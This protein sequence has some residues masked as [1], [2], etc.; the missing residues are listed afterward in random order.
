MSSELLGNYQDSDDALHVFDNDKYFE[1]WYFDA[2]FDNGYS[3]VC[4]C[5]WMSPYTEPHRPVIHMNIYTPE[6]KM[7]LGFAALEPKDC[8][9][10]LK[11]C[12]FNMAGNSVYQE[13]DKYNM[14]MHVHKI[15]ADLCFKKRI[16]GWKQHGNGLLYDEDGKKQGWIIAAPRSDVEGT[17]MIKGEIVP[18]KGQG[19]HDK[20]FGNCE[21]QDC[22]RQ[23]YWGRLYDDRFTL[24]YYW[25]FPVDESKPVIARLM[26]ALDDKPILVSEK[27]ELSVEKQEKCSDTGRDVPRKIALQGKNDSGV[28]FRCDLDISIAELV[29]LPKLSEF[30][31]YYWRSLGQHT[32]EVDDNCKRIVSSGKAVSEYFIV[33]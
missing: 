26:L 24:I 28:S 11:R 4:V 6:D 27:Y 19:Y 12:N 23:W 32:I 18:V 14:S 25:L 33:R 13:D 2:A 10:D 21:F 1:W 16:P 22:F 17:L 7:L 15:G 20:N 31:Q 30:D 8:S 3:C 5:Y 9:S 29:K